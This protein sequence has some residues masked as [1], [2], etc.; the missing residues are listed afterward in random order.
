LHGWFE[1]SP[2]ALEPPPIRRE[3]LTLAQARRILAENPEWYRLLKG[4]LQMHTVWSDGSGTIS[5]A[6]KAA[7]ERGY[8]YIAITDHTKGLRIAGG[9]DEERLEHQGY[10]LQ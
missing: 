1:L 3:F 6:S 10:C 4:D 7:I 9:L 5:S 8:Q 2:S